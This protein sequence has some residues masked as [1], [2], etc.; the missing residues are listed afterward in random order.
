MPTPDM[1]GVTNAAL[2]GDFA[3]PG[4]VVQAI[5][6]RIEPRRACLIADDAAVLPD[7]AA[8]LR[9]SFDQAAL[10]RAPIDAEEVLARLRQALAARPQALGLVVDMGWAVGKLH[11]VTGIETWGGLADRL[12]QDTGLPVIS[13]YDQD[14]VIEEMMQAA[15]RAHR[16]FVAP[17]GVYRNPHWIPAEMLEGAPLDEQ[18]SFLLGRVVPDYAGLL[19]RRQDGQMFARGTTPSWLGSRRPGIGSPTGAARWHVHCLGRLRVLI[20]NRAVDWQLP[21]GAPKKTRTLFAYL[22]QSGDK[23]A[24]ADQL[25]ELLWPE[26]G[27]E[28]QKRTRLHHTVAMLRKTLGDPASVLRDGEYYRLNAPPG[29]WIDIDTFEQLCRRGLA[30][31]KRGEL[32]PALRVYAAATQLYGGDLFED[33]PLEYVRSETDD[34]CMPRRIWLREM[35]VK[36]LYDFAKVC[37]KSGRVREALDHCQKALSIDPSSEGANAE[38]MKI[39]VAQG[40]MDAMHRQ[41]R[42]YRAALEAIGASEGAEIRMLYREL[43]RAS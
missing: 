8:D 34:W 12:A 26:E 15:L 17:S 28:A 40:R 30:L 1:D 13:V 10:D 37:S 25:G 9:V 3:L 33:L 27:S 5:A 14:L 31:F 24:H 36:L 11:G 41:Y 29:S 32:A 35:A 16:Q 18:L 6:A 42:Q 23:G 38:A 19:A 7:I 4:F 20:G 22:L 39:F 21:G 2:I 43:A